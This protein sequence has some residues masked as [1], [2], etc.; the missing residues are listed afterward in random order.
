MLSNIILGFIVMVACLMVQL[1][2]LISAMRYYFKHRYQVNSPSIWPD[3]GVISGVMLLLLIGNIGQIAVWALL[4]VFLGEFKVFADAF[5]H[6]AVNFSS[7]GYGD[8]VMSEEHRLLGALEAI[9]GILMVGVTTAALMT[10]FKDA[11]QRSIKAK[12]IDLS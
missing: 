2:L 11:F 5:Y 6:S 12:H 10:P 4:F 8:I 1:V 9:N 3:L 7:L